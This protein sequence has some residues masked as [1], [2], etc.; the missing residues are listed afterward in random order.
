MAK[1]EADI[2]T[3]LAKELKG[4]IEEIPEA[5]LQFLID[6]ASKRNASSRSDR[7]QGEEQKSREGTAFQV[8]RPGT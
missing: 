6:Q 7:P 5:G 2:R 4:L 1:R 8:A 3:K